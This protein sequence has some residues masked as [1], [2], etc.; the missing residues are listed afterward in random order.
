[1]WELYK[2]YWL[3]FGAVLTDMEREGI[4]INMQHMD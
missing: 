1:M 3:P 4:E 2:R